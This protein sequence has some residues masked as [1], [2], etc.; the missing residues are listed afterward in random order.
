MKCINRQSASSRLPLTAGLLLL[1]ACACTRNGRVEER[2]L[3]NGVHVALLEDSRCAA[4]TVRLFVKAGS[5][6]ETDSTSGISRLTEQ[7][8]FRQTRDNPDVRRFLD[9]YG[10]QFFTSTTPDFMY[11]CSTADAAFAEPILSAAVDVILNS[12]FTDSLVDRRKREIAVSIENDRQNPRSRILDGF[13]KNAFR[14]HPYRLLPT[15]SLSAVRR[16]T[17]GDVERYFQ[18]TFVPE[19]LTIAV[20]GRFD[21][22]LVKRLVEGP[23]SRFERKA[24]TVFAWTPEPPRDT[25]LKIVRYHDLPT[26]VSLVSVG[27]Q[28]PSVQND[29]TYAMDVLV[30]LLGIPGMGQGFRLNRQLRDAM[31]SVYSAW[32]EYQTPRE[33]GYL[34]ITAVCRSG[35]ADSVQ[36]RILREVAILRNDP[37]PPGEIIRAKQAFMAQRLF[38]GEGP[39]ES[40]FFIG[41][42]SMMKNSGYEDTYLERIRSVGAED[43]RAVARRYLK[44]DNFVSVLLLPKR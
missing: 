42:W 30:A 40:S 22:K 20:T 31:P 39:T 36:T 10:V 8:L 23:L 6:N 44:D 41:F 16:F 12:T 5:I 27:W 9:G 7:S 24:S 28:A 14:V 13:L 17:S 38:S 19:N 18:S 33:P 4:V 21:R 35:A 25:P 34:L 1:A 37:V 29:D 15:G 43:V 11:F 3:P 2:V 32:A 26:N